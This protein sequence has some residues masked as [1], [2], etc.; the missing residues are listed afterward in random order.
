MTSETVFVAVEDLMEGQ[1]VDT[2]GWWEPG[3]NE[4]IAAE[5][6]YAV[7]IAVEEETP[8]CT[9]VHFMDFP[10]YGLPRGE[11]VKVVSAQESL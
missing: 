1:M 9:V 11:M 5:N 4:E 7:V 8:E 10:S 2:E 3:S 6:L